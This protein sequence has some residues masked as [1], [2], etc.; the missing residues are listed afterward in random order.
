MDVAKHINI[1][2][3]RWFDHVVRMDEGSPLAR[4]FNAVVGIRDEL[5]RVGKTE[6]ARTSLVV[7]NWIRRAQSKGV[8]REDLRQADPR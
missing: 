3:F 8:W 6:E 4:V 1:Q 7:T 5:I 2:W